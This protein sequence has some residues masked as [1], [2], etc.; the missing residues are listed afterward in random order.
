MS[1]PDFC[2]R[3]NI[4]WGHIQPNRANNTS[5]ANFPQNIW[6]GIEWHH[7]LVLF[8]FH[9]NLPGTVFA[10]HFRIGDATRTLQCAIY[11]AAPIQ[12]HEIHS[13][14]GMT[15]KK[16]W[17]ASA[18]PPFITT[19]PSQKQHLSKLWIMIY[20]I[21]IYS[22]DSPQGKWI[23]FHGTRNSKAN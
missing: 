22:S 14:F 15:W 5:N 2:V 1:R 10:A 13:I 18:L 20:I 23:K 9:H 16:N 7:H 19:T 17:T 8:R 6:Q 11:V 3:N 21:N 12:L 4:F